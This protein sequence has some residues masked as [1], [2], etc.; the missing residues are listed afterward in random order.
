M[1]HAAGVKLSN[2]RSIAMAEP[3]VIV[4]PIYPGVTHLD[5]TG[6]HQFLVRLPH[7]QVI[8]ATTAGKP[9]SADG[10]TFAGLAALEDIERCDVLCVPGGLG[11]TEAMQDAEF[12][13]AIRRLG[14]GARY[15]T[16]VCTGSLI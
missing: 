7:A 4:I 2:Q 5:F 16:S 1:H 6:P 3:L 11:S 9:I 8:V 13:R 14:A 12:M 10:I 15:L